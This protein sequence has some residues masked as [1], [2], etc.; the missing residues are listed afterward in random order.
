D[1]PRVA[2]GLGEG[3][4]V[5]AAG[6]EH[7]RALVDLIFEPVRNEAPIFPTAAIAGIVGP[8]RRVVIVDRPRALVGRPSRV[9]GSE[10]TTNDEKETEP[11]A[12][13]HTNR[14]Y[15]FKKATGW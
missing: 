6:A 3:A 14:L 1:H 13:C 4:I 8:V 2:G 15:C 7:A 12:A 11:E 10:R 9:R 5:V